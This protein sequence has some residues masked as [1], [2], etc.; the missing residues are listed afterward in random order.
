MNYVRE[1]YRTSSGTGF[2]GFLDEIKVVLLEGQ[3]ALFV[4]GWAMLSH[5]SLAAVDCFD[6]STDSLLG[7]VTEFFPRSD[8][9]PG[10]MAFEARLPLSADNSHNY[11]D[12]G[13]LTRADDGRL[14]PIFHHSPENIQIELDGRCNLACVMCPQAFGVHSG[15]LSID[16]LETLRPVIERSECVE[17]NH[18]GEALLSPILLQLLQMVPPHKHIAF[19]CNGTALKAKVARQLLEYAPPVRS[20]SISIDAGTEESFYKIR[21]T[22]LSKIMENAR[23]FKKARDEAGLTF[24]QLTLTCTVIS[25]FMEFVPDIV[26]LAAELDKSFR[27]WPL[28]GSGLHGG[29]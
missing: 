12:Y 4:R 10:A 27:Y 26:G 17:I 25:D 15:P 8:L 5:G 29:A 6:V 9:P 13:L 7:S 23:A 22:S 21:G 3:M 20:I 19:N 1:Q 11:F 14:F 2:Q 16:D 28:T 18:Q 24:P